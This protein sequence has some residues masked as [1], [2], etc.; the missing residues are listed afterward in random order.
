MLLKYCRPASVLGGF[1]LGV[2]WMLIQMVFDMFFMVSTYADHS[3]QLSGVNYLFNMG[4]RHLN[5]LFICMAVG[6]AV[7]DALPSREAA[8]VSSGAHV[9]VA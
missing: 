6:H 8:K 4:L 9:K 1:L 7:E 3:G 2:F 5:L